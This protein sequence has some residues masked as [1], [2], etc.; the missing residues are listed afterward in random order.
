MRAVRVRRASGTVGATLTLAL[1]M[2][3]FGASPANADSIV[4]I[5]DHNVWLA[6][7]NGSTQTQVTDDGTTGDPYYSPSQADD[8]TILV[9]KGSDID[10]QFHRLNQDGQLLVPPFDHSAPAYP[11]SVAVSPDGELIAYHVKLIFGGRRGRPA[12]TSRTPTPSRT[13]K[14]SPPRSISSIPLG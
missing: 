12:R 2:L 7:P 11:Q 8:G 4:Y 13:A 3:G 1:A 14:R 6:E 10:A 5:K 9:L